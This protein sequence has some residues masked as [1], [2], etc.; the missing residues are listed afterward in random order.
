MSTNEDRSYSDEYLKAAHKHVIYNRSEI[1]SSTVCCCYYCGYQFDPRDP[2]LVLIFT[3]V[4]NRKGLDETV[5]CPMCGIDCVLGDGSGYPVAEPGF[6]QAMTTY[7][8]N[9]YSRIDADIPPQKIEWKRI[10]V[11]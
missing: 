7:W 9:G 11:D 10:D 3:D 5:L 1:E 2:E 6:I 4:N 8:F